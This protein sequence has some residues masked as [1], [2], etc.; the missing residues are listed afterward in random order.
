[1]SADNNNYYTGVKIIIGN[2]FFFLSGWQF[3]VIH[4]VTAMAILNLL[5][6]RVGEKIKKIL[7]AA[8]MI[9]SCTLIVFAVL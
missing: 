8:L 3:I 4:T 5:I 7:C 6:P 2:G 1:M 9:F